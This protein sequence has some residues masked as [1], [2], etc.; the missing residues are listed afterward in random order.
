MSLLNSPQTN[1]LSYEEKCPINQFPNQCY[2]MQGSFNSHYVENF[3]ILQE[4]FECEWLCDRNKLAFSL[5]C[6]Y[7]N[8]KI[9]FQN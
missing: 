2:S 9:H 1:P 4:G 8:N 3:H 5:V 7:R 6:V